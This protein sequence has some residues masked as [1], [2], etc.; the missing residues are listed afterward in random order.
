MRVTNEHVSIE[1]DQGER[2]EAVGE[3]S[4]EHEPDD[5]TGGSGEI[6]ATFDDEIG[7]HRRIY[8]CDT[9][10]WGAHVEDEA[11]A[12]CSKWWSS[13]DDDPEAQVPHQGDDLDD[14]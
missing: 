2:K 7:A 4:G 9:E 1:A 8:E 13:K 11:V 12:D 14:E 3:R 6:F 10:T 5:L